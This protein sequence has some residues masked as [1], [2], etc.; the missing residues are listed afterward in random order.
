MM[1]K[2][3]H[4]GARNRAGERASQIL[5]PSRLLSPNR[6]PR[7]SNPRSAAQIR[8][9]ASLLVPCAARRRATAITK[10]EQAEILHLKAKVKDIQRQLRN[11]RKR[12]GRAKAAR[13]QDARHT[14]DKEQ[15]IPGPGSRSPQRNR[16]H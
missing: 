2:S 6:M 1:I 4:V 8:Q 16:L 9:T 10:G 5:L 7:V 11:E 15:H 3:D 12:T 14:E 13:L